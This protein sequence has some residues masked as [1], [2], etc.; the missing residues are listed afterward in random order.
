[1][2]VGRMEQ[3][4]LES[5]A[6]TAD[7]GRSSVTVTDTGAWRFSNHCT[8]R[9]RRISREKAQTIMVDAALKGLPVRIC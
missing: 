3:S 6:A 5:G 7:F 9:E 8:G 1:M 2:D 4:A